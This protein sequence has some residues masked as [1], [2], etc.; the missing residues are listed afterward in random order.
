M[1]QLRHTRS[2]RLCGRSPPPAT[3]WDSPPPLGLCSK[4]ASRV[5]SMRQHIASANAATPSSVTHFSFLK[6]ETLVSS[7]NQNISYNITYSCE[8]WQGTL[9]ASMFGTMRGFYFHHTLKE[10]SRPVVNPACASP[11]T[12]WESALRQGRHMRG[13]R[14]GGPPPRKNPL[15]Q[16]KPGVSS[17]NGEL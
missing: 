13:S 6:K 16:C 1:R 4:Q 8:K 12:K 14:L 11:S 3:G 10:G 9:S 2:L 17:G 7:S 15:I 5:A